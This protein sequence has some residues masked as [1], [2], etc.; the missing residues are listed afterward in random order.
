MLYQRNWK[1][2][3]LG[4]HIF[5]HWKKFKTVIAT[6]YLYYLYDD[7]TIGMVLPNTISGN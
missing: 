3:E 7:N 4:S 1:K 6:K 5:I 2:A